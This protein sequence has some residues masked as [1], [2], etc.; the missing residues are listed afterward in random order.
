MPD[1]EWS[2]ENN[3]GTIRLNRPE[4][5]NAFTFEMVHEWA[6]L[7]RAAKDDDDVRVVVLTGT[8][9][10]AFCSGIDL[11]SIS[12]ANA[13]LTPLERKSHLHDEIHQVAYAI[14]ALDKPVIA[15]ING[16]A[17]GAG[18]DMALMCD[19]RIAARSARLS[20]GYIKVG[21]TPGDGG[22][23]YLPRLVGTAKALELLLT[24]D[25]VSAS[26]ALQ[27]GM[28][29]RVVEDSELGAATQRLAEQ[30]ASAPPVTV[31]MIKRA[32]YQSSRSDLRTALDLIS[33]HFAVVASTQDAA[34]A[35]SAM[36]EK[37]S[38]AFVGK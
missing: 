37:R 10:K 23:Y 9:D 31:R 13:E 8:G 17:V 35:L 7:L 30:I 4:Q 15:S 18:L 26:E 5:R 12:N 14:E 25:F 36:K 20:E 22:A 33:S 2:V 19:M 16:A 21:L 32:T 27:I 24:G 28:V 29:N 3:V 1:L 34:E 38:P 11:G 6:R